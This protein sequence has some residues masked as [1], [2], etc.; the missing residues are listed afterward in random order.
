MSESDVWYSAKQRKEGRE[1]EGGGAG[2]HKHNAKQRR[3]PPTRC[4]A[5]LRD[6]LWY[7]IEPPVSIAHAPLA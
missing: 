2:R 6:L 4:C 1:V 5:A 3:L 7:T